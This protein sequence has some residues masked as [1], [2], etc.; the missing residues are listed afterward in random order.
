L[1]VFVDTHLNVPVDDFR[2]SFGMKGN[3]IKRSSF[4][5]RRIVRV[6]H[7]VLEKPFHELAATVR[8]IRTTDSGSWQRTS[9][10]R[11]S[12]I[13]QI[14]ELLGGSFPIV[15]VWL[16]PCL[17]VSCSSFRSAVAFDTMLGPLIDEFAP[18]V[19]VLRRLCPATKQFF[20]SGTITEFVLVGIGFG[21]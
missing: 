8:N 17:P 11:D 18:I 19:I 20:E 3:K 16:V 10:R 7:T 1:Q 4:F 6:F 2:R 5:A 13:M 12:S 9:N 15:Y 21:R 14:E